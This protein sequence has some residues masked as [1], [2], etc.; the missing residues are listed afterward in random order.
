MHTINPEL[1]RT[2]AFYKDWVDKSLALEN[3]LARMKMEQDI[4]MN[5]LQASCSR[6]LIGYANQIPYSSMTPIGQH[7]W[8]APYSTMQDNFVS[9][10]ETSCQTREQERVARAEKLRKTFKMAAD[11]SACLTKENAPYASIVFDGI[12]VLTAGNLMEAAISVA[13]IIDTVDRFSGNEKH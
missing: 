13:S 2:N 9:Y 1:Y 8:R 5:N 10:W 3:E 4:L 6:R 12:G 7:Q 11:V